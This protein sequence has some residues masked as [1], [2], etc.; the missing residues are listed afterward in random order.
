MVFQALY[1]AGEFRRSGSSL[2]S[3]PQSR[4]SALEQRC[5]LPERPGWAQN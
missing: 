4:L 3:M 2:P 1:A 5:R